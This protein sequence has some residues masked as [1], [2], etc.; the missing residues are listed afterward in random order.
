M[1]VEASPSSETSVAVYQL[2]WRRPDSSANT[3]YLYQ[4]QTH[5]SEPLAI[6][7]LDAQNLVLQ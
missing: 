6:N 4:V 5:N 1:N 2:T 7:Q 3:L